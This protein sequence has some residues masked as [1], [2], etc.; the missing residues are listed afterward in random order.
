MRGDKARWQIRGLAI[1]LSAGLLGSLI[2]YLAKAHLAL[3]LSVG[4]V[5]CLIIATLL[6]TRYA[7]QHQRLT[8]KY[9]SILW[10]PLNEFF[11]ILLVKIEIT[12]KTQH[13]IGIALAEFAYEVDG[14]VA[15]NGRVSDDVAHAVARVAGSKQ[16][17][18]PLSGYTEKI[19]AHGS[20]SGW[21][22]TP[23]RCDPAGG[24]PKCI[25]T[26]RDEIGGRYKI[27]I[28]AQKAHIYKK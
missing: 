20:I 12:N 1:E 25:V 28:P 16:Y 18:P 14:V 2:A 21:F 11:K 27:A 3:V 15:G 4:A 10:E 9:Q 19:P 22:A 7:R 8:A 23:V 17:Y 26:V 24:T 13:S 6:N 5:V